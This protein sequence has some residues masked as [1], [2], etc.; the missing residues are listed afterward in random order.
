VDT[1]RSRDVPWLTEVAGTTDGAAF[2]PV[3]VRTDYAATRLKVLSYCPSDDATRSTSRPLAAGVIILCLQQNHPSHHTLQVL[4]P[5]ITTGTGK[6][7]CL[8]R[9]S[10][11]PL[12]PS[13]FQRQ[14]GTPKLPHIASVLTHFESRRQKPS[15]VTK[16]TTR[17]TFALRLE[18]ERRP[19]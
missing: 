11:S 6:F 13:P 10:L 17:E 4:A 1:I 7:P 8:L 2:R 14:R 18:T 12:T 5:P 15:R 9:S 3:S 19:V 16:G